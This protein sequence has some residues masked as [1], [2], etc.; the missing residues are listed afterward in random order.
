MTGPAS[1]AGAGQ[2]TADPT[3]RRPVGGGWI[4]SFGA[5]YLFQNLAWA[6]PSQLLLAQ[7]IL[8]WYPGEKE[9][10][11]AAL[12]AV[13]GVASLM[14][15]PLAGW[16]SDHTGGR[17]G[18]RAPWVLGGA[19]VAAAALLALAAAPGFG[20]LIAGWAVFQLAVAASINASQA[21]PPDTV[22]DRQYGTVSGVMGLTYTLGLVL[23]TAVATLLGIGAAYAVTAALLVTGVVQ[24]LV[25]H[26]DVTA[27]R[28]PRAPRDDAPSAA[29][30]P[31]PAAGTAAG[32]ADV[33]AGLFRGDAYHD[34]R[35]VFAAR[36]LVTAG[37]YVALFYLFYYLRDR[38]GVADPDGGVLALTG[39][40]ALC[41]VVTAMASGRASD[42]SGRRRVYVALSS[43]GVAV[44]CVLMAFAES[45]AAVVAAA[46]I[47]GLSWGVY[48]AVDQALINEVLPDADARGR[49][50]GVMNLAVA[51]PN[52]LAPV[53]AAASL[54]WLGGYPGLYVFSAA[55]TAVGAVIIRR[56]RTVP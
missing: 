18:L 33:A 45:F 4:A 43:V 12:M 6:A 21:I 1:A 22:P 5:M 16:L 23:G 24:F 40:Y 17:F 51:G 8:A 28:V 39:V 54:A 55:I 20:A 2:A 11:L 31:D 7:Q 35:W 53:L 49:D 15:H 42:R 34:Y 14:G 30:G 41:V 25:A 9:Q 19:L 46:V 10:R 3:A 26:G 38:I 13:G 29:P 48:M 37:N 50:V 52:V 27:V 32:P 44:A 47:L 36:F 56:V